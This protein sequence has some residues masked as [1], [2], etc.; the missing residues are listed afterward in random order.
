MSGCHEWEKVTNEYIKLYDFFAEGIKSVSEKIRIGGPSAA[1]VFLSDAPRTDEYGPLVDAMFIKKF[2]THIKSGTNHANGQ[3][4]TAFDFYTVHTYGDL[5]RCVKE[6]TLDYSQCTD[7]LINYKKVAAD[8]GFP[9]IEMISDEWEMTGGGFCTSDKYPI[10]EYRNGEVFSSHYF[11]F[12]EDIIK[13]NISLTALMICLSGQH[14][15]PR[16]F[17]GTRTFATKNGFKTPI[18]NAYA[19]SAMLGETILEST[20]DDKIG[21]IPTLCDNG[22]IAVAIFNY[23]KNLL[24]K[25]GTLNT[26][27]HIIVSIKKTATHTRHGK[28]LAGLKLILRMRSRPSTVPHF[29]SHGIMMKYSK[30]LNIH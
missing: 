28:S 4:G 21:V 16:D 10:V 26:P 20:S 3:T 5:H 2:L 29:S 24:K 1:F 15:L 8:C 14:H 7:M 17:C 27:L 18:Y 23:S 6:N 13:N 11:A 22:D 30:V 25:N 9:D 19:L 12:I